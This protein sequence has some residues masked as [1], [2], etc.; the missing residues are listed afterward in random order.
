MSHI[1][2]CKGDS[3]QTDIGKTR[4]PKTSS[5]IRLVGILDSIQ[6]ALG[7]LLA[8]PS[9]YK[10]GIYHQ[11]DYIYNIMGNIHTQ[12]PEIPEVDTS[13]LYSYIKHMDLPP[14]TR[15][16]LPTEKTA[17]HHYVRSLIRTAEL[18][19]RDIENELDEQCNISIYLN[20]LSSFVFALIMEIEF[21]SKPEYKPLTLSNNIVFTS[22]SILTIMTSWLFLNN[23]NI[24]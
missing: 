11:M 13:V 8:T 9:K 6:A 19:V 17:T 20:R 1:P 23:N 12:Y 2:S 22:L 14:L 7:L 24:L 21:K 16:L 3:G 4:V 18:D 10:H 5:H 15:F